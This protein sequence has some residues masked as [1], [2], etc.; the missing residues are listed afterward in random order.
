MDKAE[1]LDVLLID[2]PF[3]ISFMPSLGLT[4]LKESVKRKGYSSYIKYFCLKYAKL[5]GERN[6]LFVSYFK[7]IDMLGEWLFS[8][9]IFD[10]L[11]DEEY[12]NQLRP[13]PENI[14]FFVGRK[15][16]SEIH[17]ETISLIR[18]LKSKSE[19]FIQ[20]CLE[21]VIAINPKIVGFTSVFQQNLASF[22][23]AKRIKEALP[24]TKIVFGG[25]NCEGIMGQE[26]IRQFP[27]IDIVV[28]GEADTLF[29]EMV[30]DLLNNKDDYI[31]QP[32]VFCRQNSD[33]F[34]AGVTNTPL[35]YDMDNLPYPNYDDYF[36]QYKSYGLM[37]PHE[38][39]ILFES[40]R[41]CWFGEKSH[42][43]FCGQNGNNMIHR[44][45][46]AARLL[47]EVKFLKE[48][49][50]VSRFTTTDN[51][52]DLHY[53]K[54]F[55]P[56]LAAENM[57]LKIFYEMK[58]NL[59][60]DQVKLLKSAGITNI[61]PG[62]ENLSSHVLE[63]MKKGVKSIQNVQLLKWC[64]EYGFKVDWGIIWGFPGETSEDYLQ[65]AGLIPKITHLL[66]PNRITFMRIH[67]FSPNF[68]YP[69]VFGIKKIE[70]YP[71]YY[72]IYPFAKETVYNLAYQFHHEYDCDENFNQALDAV[73]KEVDLWKAAYQQSDLFFIDR[74]DVLIV[75]D[76]RPAAPSPYYILNLKERFLYLLCDKIQPF[77]KIKQEFA[78][79]FETEA[80]EAEIQGILDSLLNRNLMIREK[81]SYLSLAIRQ[82]VYSPKNEV[83]KKLVTVLKDRPEGDNQVTINNNNQLVIQLNVKR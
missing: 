54:D 10:N 50:Q 59:T 40:S 38:H 57:N 56:A 30:S 23:L 68:N 12:L 22:S 67:R 78:K 5:V 45:K 8:G 61:Q 29:P 43:T 11:P 6:Y 53:F 35:V 32:G 62:I 73:R 69:E 49:Y 19:P 52:M 66:P 64:K 27:F 58:P 46:S 15:T 24:D 25:A 55:V 80:D 4:L 71:A 60:K 13:D 76:I 41:G 48:K 33:K 7:D 47:D 37:K 82:G 79:F 14:K 34:S 21:E 28:S 31:S 77:V 20:G 2:M 36:E 44:S 42:C 39:I 75:F 51:I 74:E 3:A 65:I 26:M 16:T 18:E 63:I 81:N 1:N 83:M 72:N 70:P 9:T 17:P